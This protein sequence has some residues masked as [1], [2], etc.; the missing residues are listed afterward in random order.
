MTSDLNNTGQKKSEKEINSEKLDRLKAG[1]FFT[2]VT[3]FGLLSGFGYSVSSVKRKETTTTK[4]AKKGGEIAKN[5]RE[6]ILDPKQ[7]QL[8]NLY[9]SGTALARKA[10]LRATIYSVSGVSLLCL[11]IWTLSG[12]RD[13]NEFRQKIGSLFPRLKRRKENEGRT[14]FE[15]LTDLFQYVIDED[16]K[17]KEEKKATT[18][19]NNK[20]VIKEEKK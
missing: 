1:I 14:E 12:A 3:A 18:T 13:F 2:F 5:Q 9:D 19:T 8:N 4:T 6:L 16:K 20:T 11:S 17:Q 7:R 15:N 10:L